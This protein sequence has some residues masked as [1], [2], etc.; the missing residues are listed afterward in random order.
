MTTPNPA[1]VVKAL[2]E[3][4][5]LLLVTMA[6]AECLRER[7]DAIDRAV[8]AEHTYTNEYEGNR[9]T[10]P[11]ESW[12]MGDDDAALYHPRRDAAIRAAGFDPPEGYCPALMAESAQTEAE[13]ALVKA[14]EP[15]FGV[16]N[17]QL[18]SHFANGKTG[19]DHRREFIDLLIGLV[20]NFPGYESPNLAA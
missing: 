5:N 16:T 6:H 13:N 15:F 3:A 4:V 17:D 18:L 8:L 11:K 2:T 14:S 1:T 10:E 12:Q 9:I 19:L 7:V 20:V